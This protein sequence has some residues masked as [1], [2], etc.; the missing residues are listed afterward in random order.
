MLTNRAIAPRLMVVGHARHGKDTF[1]D[2]LC[3][4]SNKIYK[5]RSSSECA[6]QYAIWPKLDEIYPA[7]FAEKLRAHAIAWGF[8]SAYEELYE[9]RFNYRD[10]W[11]QLI[12]D[13]NKDDKTRLMKQLYATSNIYV[14]IR[15]KQEFYAGRDEGIFDLSIWVD[16]PR[17]GAEKTNELNPLDCDLI[18]N[19]C[20]DLEV[21]E[22][23]ARDILDHICPLF[24]KEGIQVNHNA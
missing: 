11:K 17:V 6:I 7:Y 13:Y 1:A 18:V 2:M 19:N 4:L 14:G 9:N 23:R 10:E 5:K 16:N 8:D 15:S 22:Q 20:G 12:C 24:F 21:L 3:D